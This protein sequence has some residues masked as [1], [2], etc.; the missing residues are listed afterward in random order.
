M[1]KSDNVDEVK[2]QQSAGLPSYK[3]ASLGLG[4][5]PEHRDIFQGLTVRQNLLLG[6]KNTRR[7]GKSR[8]QDDDAAFLRTGER[9]WVGDAI[10]SKRPGLVQHPT[11][12]PV[13]PTLPIMLRLYRSTSVVRAATSEATRD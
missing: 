13:E 4:Y 12:C 3:I 10:R 7:P 11:E 9:R 5:V 6:I 8:L 1:S 2:G